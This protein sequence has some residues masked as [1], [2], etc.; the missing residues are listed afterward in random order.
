MPPSSPGFPPSSPPPPLE[1]KVLQTFTL[2][3][4]IESFDAVAFRDSLATTAGVAESA[5]ALTYR[6]ASVIVDATIVT[7]DPAEQAQVASNLDSLAAIATS[8]ATAASDLLGVSVLSIAAPQ[9][10]TITM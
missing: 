6:S 9:P 8:N 10:V 4:P 7:S 1:L 2:D 5:V 3:V